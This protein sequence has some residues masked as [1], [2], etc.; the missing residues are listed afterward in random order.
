MLIPDQINIRQCMCAYTYM[1]LQ[2][3]REQSSDCVRLTQ[4]RGYAFK[5]PGLPRVY[6]T[7][8]KRLKNVKWLELL[9]PYRKQ[10]AGRKQEPVLPSRKGRPRCP[11]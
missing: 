6:I 1:N 7:E 2:C 9:G 8:G 4:R 11:D 10:A 5:K 3:G